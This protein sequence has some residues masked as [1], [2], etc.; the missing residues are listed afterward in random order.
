VYFT[1][2]TALP[3][4][5]KNYRTISP[6]KNWDRVFNIKETLFKFASYT[7]LSFYYFSTWE[8]ISGEKLE[9]FLGFLREVI[10]ISG[11]LTR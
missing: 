6:L 9:G 3:F 2:Q 5:S 10:I 7:K 4:K 8:D 11:T 1:Y